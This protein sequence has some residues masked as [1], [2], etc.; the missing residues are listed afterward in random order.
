M[1]IGTDQRTRRNL[2]RER[3]RSQQRK[4]HFILSLYPKIFDYSLGGYYHRERC[5]RTRWYYKKIG[6]YFQMIKGATI[7]LSLYSKN[8][9][10]DYSL[11]GYSHQERWPRTRRNSYEHEGSRESERRLGKCTYSHREGIYIYSKLRLQCMILELRHRD[12]IRIPWLKHIM[13]VR[14]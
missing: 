10:F 6:G 14:P 7:Y 9:F 1:H 13:K 12:K 8:M 2:L 4:T 11:G 5:A 3:Q